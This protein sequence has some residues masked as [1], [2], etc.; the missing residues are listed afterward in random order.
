MGF[1]PVTKPAIVVVV[2]L[3]GAPPGR[4]GGAVAAPVFK[5]VAAEAL[6]V[7]DV[8]RD[9][10]DASASDEELEDLDEAPQMDPPAGLLALAD[11]EIE[12]GDGPRV[13]N[14]IGMSMRAVVEQSAAAGLP[15]VLDG[16]GKVLDQI[17]AP[18][19]ILHPG[20]QIRVQFDR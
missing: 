16:S 12:Q 18:G 3:N 11:E 4:Y 2:T 9:L 7:L 19:R 5:T 10:P 13:P 8:Q 1:A 14:Y 15:V 6:R 20:G 17:P